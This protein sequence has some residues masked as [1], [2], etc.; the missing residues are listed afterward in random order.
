MYKRPC[1]RL[2][3][4]TLAATHRQPRLSSMTF[5]EAVKHFPWLLSTG[6]N[7][8]T[9]RSMPPRIRRFDHLQGF[10]TKTVSALLNIYFML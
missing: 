1:L 9:P 3:S 5:E 8:K 4:T 6:E 7:M 2:S 10:E